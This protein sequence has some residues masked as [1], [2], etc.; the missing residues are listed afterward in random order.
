MTHY[1]EICVTCSVKYLLG[2]VAFYYIHRLQFG[3]HAMYRFEQKVK[4]KLSLC[5]TKY[6]TIKRIHRLIKRHAIINV[7]NW[8]RWV[9]SYIPLSLYLPSDW[10]LCGPQSHWKSKLNSTYDTQYTLT[11]TKFHGNRSVVSELKHA[12]RWSQP[13]LYEFTSRT[14]SKTLKETY[15]CM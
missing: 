11:S 3:L 5:L 1:N 6:H 2:W 8:L 12:N 14:S 9:I 4:V 15:V 10:R 13:H 7:G